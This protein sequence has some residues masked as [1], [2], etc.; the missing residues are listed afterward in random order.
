M[1]KIKSFL[2]RHYFL[3]LSILIILLSLVILRTAQNRY[4]NPDEFEHVHSAWYVENNQIPYLDYFEN[5]NPL[6]WYLIAPVL[7]LLGNSTQVLIVLRLLMFIFVLGIGFFTYRIAAEVSRSK[8]TARIAVLLMFSLLLFVESAIEIRPDVPEVF[9]GLVSFHYLI[10]YFQNRQGREMVFSGLSAAIAFLFTQKFLLLFL[11]LILIFGY[12]LLRRQI[13]FS[14]IFIFILC[15]SFPLM[16]FGIGLIV[17]GAGKDY[18]LTGWLFNLISLDSF[19]AWGVLKTFITPNILFWVTVPASV[20]FV[21]LEKKINPEIKITALLGVGL[22]LPVFR[23][24][25]PYPQYF[26]HAL[27]FFSIA[28]GYF[29]AEVFNRFKCDNFVRLIVMV[30]F[31]AEPAVFLVKKSQE[32]N[33]SQLAMINYVLQNTNESDYVYDGSLE[34]NLFRRDLHYFWFHH[35]PWG[36]LDQYRRLAQNKYFGSYVNPEYCHYDMCNMIKSK[37]P[38]FILGFTYVQE[39]CGLPQLYK[40][41]EFRKIKIRKK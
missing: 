41:T 22:F 9:F 18:L 38:K 36:G 3:I 13:S 2:A 34:Y 31:L 23:I 35:R 6:L 28:S 32:K 21:L 12:R 40:N 8:E 29:L 25:H 24:K 20:I 1:S 5:H 37:N 17:S 4:F 27:P 33:A 15:F 16:F 30:S 7:L 26:L 11:G 39:K 19:S 14:A 10:R